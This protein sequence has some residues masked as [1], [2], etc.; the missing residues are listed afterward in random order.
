[1]F[2]V[3]DRVVLT[4]QC[5]EYH[6]NMFGNNGETFKEWN[7]DMRGFGEGT[8]IEIRDVEQPPYD[9]M[10]KQYAIVEWENQQTLDYDDEDGNVVE[11]K[12]LDRINLAWLEKVDWL[13]KHTGSHQYDS[14][15]RWHV[16]RGCC[17]R[18]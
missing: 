13:R 5:I 7:I 14:S 15:S 8:I 6:E 16:C 2:K 17:I 10:Y 12:I 4:D 18:W 11:S 9:D 3:N 1:M